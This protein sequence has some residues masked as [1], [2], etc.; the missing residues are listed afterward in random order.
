MLE[1][2]PLLT[3]YGFVINNYNVFERINRGHYWYFYSRLI[4]QAILLY[5][6][7][8]YILKLISIIELILFWEVTY[9][10]NRISLIYN[11]L[12]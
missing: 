10:N 5:S 11:F 9:T 7:Y 6:R 1:L 8:A 4:Q 12:M 3:T 2:R